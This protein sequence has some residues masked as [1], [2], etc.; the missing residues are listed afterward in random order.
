MKSSIEYDGSFIFTVTLQV[1]I[2]VPQVAVIV[3]L[4]FFKGVITP[5]DI[6]AIVPSFTLHTILSVV[7]VGVTVAISVW[8]SK[9]V[10]DN[11][12]LSKVISVQGIDCVDD[13]I[14]V[15]VA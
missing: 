7:F 5:L 10:K 4:P 11:V 1:A 2:L 15:I 3:Q 13:T 8:G 12:F 6:V 9:V 14:Y